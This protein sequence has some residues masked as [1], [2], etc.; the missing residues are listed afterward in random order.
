MGLLKERATI[1]NEI[2]QADKLDLGKGVTA[3][4]THGNVEKWLGMGLAQM[5][6][7]FLEYVFQGPEHDAEI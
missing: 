3:L 5:A 4:M 2:Y 1:T 6:K 7:E